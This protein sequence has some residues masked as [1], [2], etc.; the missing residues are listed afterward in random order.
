MSDQDQVKPYHAKDAAPGQEAADVVAEV[1]QH[2]AER[3]EAAKQKVGPKSPPKWMLPLTVNLGVLALYFLI[4][5]PEFLVVTA[6]DDPRT[7]VEVDQG[8]R[9]S[10]HQYGIV[11]IDAFLAANGRLPASLDEVP[12]AAQLNNAAAGL[13]A[14][15][16][17]RPDSTYFLSV[18]TENGVT[19]EFDSRTQSAASFAPDYDL[20]G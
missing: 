13:S 14:T 15:Y 12:L 11:Q 18:T 17:P 8:A 5:Q 10:V 20:P 2:A 16:T 1:L 3:E 9:R 6:A 4:A 19:L 7:A